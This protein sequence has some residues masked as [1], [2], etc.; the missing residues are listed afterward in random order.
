MPTEAGLG[1]VKNT[2]NV[3]IRSFVAPVTT[4]VVSRPGYAT[5]LNSYPMAGIRLQAGLNTWFDASR[6]GLNNRV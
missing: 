5:C 2:Y 4:Y 6:V 1:W 3:D